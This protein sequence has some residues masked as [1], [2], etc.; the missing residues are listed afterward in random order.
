MAEVLLGYRTV[1]GRPGGLRHVVRVVRDGRWH[2]IRALCGGLQGW[3]LPNGAVEAKRADDV[4]FGTALGRR[5]CP[6]CAARIPRAA[7]AS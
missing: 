4:E 2:V 3:A 6:R 5:P 1:Y 7:V